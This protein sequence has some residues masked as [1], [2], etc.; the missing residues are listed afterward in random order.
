MQ[1]LPLSFSQLVTSC[2]FSLLFVSL[3]FFFF[4]LFIS[5]LSNSI[6]LTN[7]M[8]HKSIHVAAGGKISPFS[9]AE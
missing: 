6:C 9:M 5:L 3:L 1:P 4:I 7:F 2:L 8:Q